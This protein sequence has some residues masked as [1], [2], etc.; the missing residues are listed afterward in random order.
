MTLI[1]PKFG[2][3]AIV[4]KVSKGWAVTFIDTDSENIIDARVFPDESRAIAYAKGLIP[5]H[6]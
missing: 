6:I 1:D 5:C 2:L 4:T 3:A